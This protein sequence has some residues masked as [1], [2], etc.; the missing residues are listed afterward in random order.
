MNDLKLTGTL[1][2]YKA[3]IVQPGDEVPEGY[4]SISGVFIKGEELIIAVPEE[5]QNNP[6]L[7]NRLAGQAEWC[8]LK[9]FPDETFEDDEED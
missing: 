1:Q 3:I 4:V 8:L 2:T 9:A 7:I 5:L 6:K